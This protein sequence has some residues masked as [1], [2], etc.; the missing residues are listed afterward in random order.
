M[1]IAWFIASLMLVVGAPVANARDEPSPLGPQAGDTYE[2]RLERESKEEGSDGSS[3][4][5]TDR[6]TIVERVIAVRD[7]GLELEYDLPQAIT[8]QDRTANWQFPVRVFKPN[9]GPMQLLN[10]SEL[11]ARVDGWLKAAKWTRDVCGRWIFTWNAFRIECD[12]QSVLK[13]IEA[14]DL[15]SAD[16]QDGAPYRD[17]EALGFAPLKKQAA[18]AEGA[19]FTA[20]LKVNPEAVRQARAESDVV[21]GEIMKKP[22]TLDAAL[23]AR[24]TEAISGTILVTFETDSIGNTR[25]RT[26]V[27]KLEIKEVNGVVETK[28]VSETVERQPVGRTKS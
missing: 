25:R 12:P 28:T 1:K 13:T 3:G 19:T 10:L 4:S 5:S 21:V 15:G 20:E 7:D 11:E 9:R 6:D 17:K 24:A 16:L 23:Q 27:I 8:E 26:R 22:V 2:I 14:F 18:G